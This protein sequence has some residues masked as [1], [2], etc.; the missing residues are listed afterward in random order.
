VRR[1]GGHA[2]EGGVFLEE[3]GGGGGELVEAISTLVS[4]CPPAPV[5]CGGAA[6]RHFTLNASTTVNF[7]G[8]THVHA[9][10]SHRFQNDH[11][12]SELTLRAEARQFSGYIVLI[13]SIPTATTFDP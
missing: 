11:L 4:S 2:P 1:S 6:E 3:S 9:Y 10:M 13:G 7:T 12:G 5:S 8:S